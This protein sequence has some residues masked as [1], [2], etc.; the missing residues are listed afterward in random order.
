M[1]SFVS[2]AE[3][4]KE[5]NGGSSMLGGWSHICLLGP[6]PDTNLCS[7]EGSVSPSTMG[8]PPFQSTAFREDK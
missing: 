8:H 7:F 2:W 5:Q 3:W 4:H 1:R 6:G